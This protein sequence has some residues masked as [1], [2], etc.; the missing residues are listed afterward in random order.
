MSIFEDAWRS[1]APAIDT[2]FGTAFMV[3]P[4][5]FN[6]GGRPVSDETRDIVEITA[7]LLE[8]PV[9]ADPQG[10]RVARNTV[11][12]VATTTASI[13]FAIGALPY[14][15]LA[16]DLFVRLDNGAVYEVTAAQPDGIARI[17]CRVNK[18]ASRS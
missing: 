6:N 16:G 9:F 10:L 13:D 17:T 11:S 14:N 8:H 4:M 1:A 18:R 7:A 12:E 15:I 3:R 5:R 2:T